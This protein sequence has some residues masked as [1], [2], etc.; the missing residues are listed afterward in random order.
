MNV[1]TMTIHE[2][3]VQGGEWVHR[4]SLWRLRRCCPWGWTC[5]AKVDVHVLDEDGATVEVT[6]VRP[7]VAGLKILARHMARYGD[8][9]LA[10]IESMGGAASSTISSSSRAGTSRSPTP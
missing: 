8:P 1:N 3:R 2:E 7:D 6:A 9:I 10:V 4:N 5:L